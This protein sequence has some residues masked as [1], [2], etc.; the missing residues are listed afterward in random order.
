MQQQRMPMSSK[1]ILVFVAV[2]LNTIWSCYFCR[3][4]QSKN[5]F[6]LL[7][8]YHAQGNALKSFTSDFHTLIDFHAFNTSNIY[9]ISKELL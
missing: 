5:S 4:F 1:K 9:M 7:S 3:T 2:G 8:T 6:H